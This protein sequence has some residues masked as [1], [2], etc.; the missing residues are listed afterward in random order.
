MQRTLHGVDLTNIEEDGQNLLVVPNLL[1]FECLYRVNYLYQLPGTETFRIK[2]RDPDH[3]EF[4]VGTGITS[5]K[6]K[7]ASKMFFQV[8]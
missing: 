4:Y 1:I 8:W 7:V 3:L 2:F 5:L 6:N